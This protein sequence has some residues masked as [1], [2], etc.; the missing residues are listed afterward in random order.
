M[1]TVS[2]IKQRLVA[3]RTEPK[4]FDSVSSGQ[5]MRKLV[6]FSRKTW[7]K[8][9][10]SL[11]GASAT[12]GRDR[13]SPA[14]SRKV[15]QIER[16]QQPAAVHVRIPPMRR[17]PRGASSASSSMNFPFLSKSSCGW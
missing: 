1:E 14:Q 3:S 8:K 6:G 13:E 4:R 2:A 9:S 15:G 7:A 5:N 11:R 12:T 17:L 10:P 16:G